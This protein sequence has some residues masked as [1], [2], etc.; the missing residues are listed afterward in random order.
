M[1]FFVLFCA[2][3]V[4]PRGWFK[5]RVLALSQHFAEVLFAGGFPFFVSRAFVFSWGGFLFHRGGHWGLER[6]SRCLFGGCFLQAGRRQYQT[7]IKPADNARQQGKRQCKIT[8]QG[9]KA[10]GRCKVQ[11]KGQRKGQSKG[12]CKG[13]GMLRGRARGKARG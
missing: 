2:R 1:R 6:V 7:N 5:G 9:N 11:G 13:Q 3:C 10:K 4:F 8:R 12:Q